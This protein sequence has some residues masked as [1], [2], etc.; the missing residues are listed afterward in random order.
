MSRIILLRHGRTDA[1]DRHIY[2]GSTDLPLSDGGREELELLGNSCVW[3]DIRAFRILTSGMRRTEETLSVLFGDIPHEMETCF[4]EMDFGSFEMHS[5]EELC[6]DEAYRAWCDGDN[7]SNIAPG[8]ESGRQMS[9]RVIAAFERVLSEGADTLI[10]LHGGPIAAI[11]ANQFP[12]EEKNRFE[13]Q[14]KNG[15]GY[16]IEYQNDHK[17]YYP[18]PTGGGADG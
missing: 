14:P 9:E 5:Y 8:G 3:P 6:S 11:M 18:I 12:T 15:R 7:E 1:N 4:R 16:L 13:W 10:V 17:I 2:C